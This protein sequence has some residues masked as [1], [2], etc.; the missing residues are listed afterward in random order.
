MLFIS[1][2]FCGRVIYFLHF[3]FIELLLSICK[4]EITSEALWLKK[5][6]PKKEIEF[7]L[8]FVWSFD[9]FYQ[10]LQ[11]YRRCFSTVANLYTIPHHMYNI[12]GTFRT[13]Y[14][15][16][17][18]RIFK[19]NYPLDEKKKQLFKYYIENFVKKLKTNNKSPWFVNVHRV[20]VSFNEAPLI[21]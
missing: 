13:H 10:S 14:I 17:L 6:S 20:L 9:Y 7:Y 5:A 1:L 12:Q 2:S 16:H 19:R 15:M 21:D 11:V 3:F 18:W 4:K 8:Q